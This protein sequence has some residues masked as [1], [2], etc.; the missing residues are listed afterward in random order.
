[1]GR[2]RLQRFRR[3][4]V[5]CAVAL[6]VALLVMSAPPAHAADIDPDAVEIL[7]SMTKYVGGLQAFSVNAEV[8]VEAVD[9]QGQKL[10]L[11]SSGDLLLVRPGK[12]YSRRHAPTGLFEFFIDGKTITLL[13]REK[14]VYFQ[15]ASPGTFEQAVDSFR[16]ETGFEVSGADLLY[17]DSYPVLMTDVRSGSYIGTS[18]VNGIECHQVAFRTDKVDWQLWVQTGD[19]PLPMKYIITTKWLTGAPAFSVRLRDWN[20]QPTIAAGQFDFKAPAGAK[21]LET[22]QLNELGEV[23][24]DGGKP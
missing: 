1:M 10:Q 16:A 15:L 17:A 5:S 23:A 3:G 21:R 12:F 9:L 8:D 18:W 24:L 20:T 14:G 13:S 22:L 19:K 2:T 11:S 4:S 6:A 7:R